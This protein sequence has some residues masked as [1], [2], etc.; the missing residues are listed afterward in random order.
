[1]LSGKKSTDMKIYMLGMTFKGNCPDLRNSKAGEL[2]QELESYGLH[3]DIV[4]PQAD[5]EEL[6]KLFRQ[7]PVKMEDVKNADCLIFTSDHREFK[8]LEPEQL[9]DMMS[10]QGCCLI[11]DVRNIYKRK[12][13]EK[14][15]CKYWSL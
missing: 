2:K 15:N 5:E 11:A 8:E 3:L 14:Q 9:A 13:I 1:M 4:D 12:D 6:K 7:Q 10:P